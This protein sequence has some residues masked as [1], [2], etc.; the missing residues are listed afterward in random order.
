MKDQVYIVYLFHIYQPPWQ[1]KEVLEENYNKYYLPLLEVLESR[2]EYKVTLNISA[3]LTEQ[4]AR[5]NKAEFFERVKK[6][7]LK[8]QIE[9]V[10][11][12]A[13]HPV[14][15]LIPEEEII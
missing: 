1:T 11:S 13:Y 8:G 12:A 2:P 15:P 6:L 10:G 3:S 9:L 14:L 4:L 7:V 5:E